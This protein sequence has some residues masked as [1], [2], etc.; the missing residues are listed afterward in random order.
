[1]RKY[2]VLFNEEGFPI[3]KVWAKNKHKAVCLYNHQHRTNYSPAAMSF[4]MFSQNEWIEYIKVR[5]RL[6]P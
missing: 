3:W 6:L 1:M 2:F 4:G 5:K